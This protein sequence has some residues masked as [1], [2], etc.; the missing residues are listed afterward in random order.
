M[1][2]LLLGVNIVFAFC[3]VSHFLLILRKIILDI[4][5]KFGMQCLTLVT[6]KTLGCASIEL[7]DQYILFYS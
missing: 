3:L 7:F 5:T 4:F 6:E 1:E 2:G